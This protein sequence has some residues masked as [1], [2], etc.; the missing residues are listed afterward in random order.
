VFFTREQ[1]QA[2]ITADVPERLHEWRPIWRALLLTGCRLSEILLLRWDQV[3][4]REGVIRIEQGKTDFPKVTYITPELR[5]VLESLPRGIGKAYVFAQMPS[6]SH[7]TGV[8]AHRA[9]TAY[10]TAAQLPSVLKI[11]TLRHTCGSWLAQSGTSL[12]VIQQVLGHRSARTT[13][14]YA[15]LGAEQVRDALGTIGRMVTNE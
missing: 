10:R 4:L 11:H 2:F 7:R 3:D 5:E 15:H 14:R 8:Q 1:W 12:L 6:G 9:W 13:A